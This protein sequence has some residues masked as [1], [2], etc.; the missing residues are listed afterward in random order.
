[1]ILCIPQQLLF[2]LFRLTYQF[3]VRMRILIVDVDFSVSTVQGSWI[4]ARGFLTKID[5]REPFW[6]RVILTYIQWHEFSMWK[7]ERSRNLPTM[8]YEWMNSPTSNASLK[9][10]RRSRHRRT[11]L[12]W[13]YRP[14]KEFRSGGGNHLIHHNMR[15]HRGEQWSGGIGRHFPILRLRC[16]S[17]RAEIRAAHFSVASEG[18]TMVHEGVH[19]WNQNKLSRPLFYRFWNR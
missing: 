4:Y 2:Y 11:P 9:V 13:M 17:T 12:R 15:R 3:P 7:S 10:P 5:E 16:V 19:S 14:R 18:T 6:H 1:M 8:R